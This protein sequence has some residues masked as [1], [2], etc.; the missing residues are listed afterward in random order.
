MKRRKH[1]GIQNGFVLPNYFF[2][3]FFNSKWTQWKLLELLRT[4]KYTHFRTNPCHPTGEVTPVPGGE[5]L[6]E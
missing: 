6:T 2:I 4:D 1:E 5:M 3:I